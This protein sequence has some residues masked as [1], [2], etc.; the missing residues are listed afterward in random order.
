MK[1]TLVAHSSLS[2]NLKYIDNPSL[3]SFFA[4]REC[5][6]KTA[7]EEPES[8]DR[9]AN[10]LTKV[11][12]AGH[13]SVL[14]HCSATFE[15]S[16]VSRCLTHQLVRH[17][18]ASYSQ[19]SQRYCSASPEDSICPKTIINNPECYKRHNELLKHI[20]ETYDFYIDHG[21]PKEDARY[22][23][24]SGVSS[25]IMVSMNYRS[26]INFFHERLCARAQ[27]EIRFAAR[28]MYDLLTVLDP[29]V[30]GNTGYCK[31]SVCETKGFCTEH[32]SCHKKP[33]LD[34]IL[35]VY[36]N[37]TNPKD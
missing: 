5:Y 36:Y 28:M 3:I 11:I 1:V 22:D 30:F 19:Q 33:K 31:G 14:E 20:K 21:V 16:G 9:Y 26:L 17:R 2:D 25:N 15:L 34:D 13:T 32:N 8:Y 12:E 35:S 18:I 37:Y 7:I 29:I 6:N 23:L 4:A 27:W 10:L 24:N